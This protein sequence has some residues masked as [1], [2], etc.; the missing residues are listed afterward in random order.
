MIVLSKEQIIMLHSQLIA[1]T[2]VIDGIRDEG[3]SDSA[4]AASFQ[5][6]EDTDVYPSIMQKAARLAYGLVKNHASCR[7]SRRFSCPRH[8]PHR[9]PSAG[10]F[11]KEPLH[12]LHRSPYP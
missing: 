7:E 12:W 4:L 6:F 5:S 8:R 2:G 9:L 1:E 10:A 11:R 3:M